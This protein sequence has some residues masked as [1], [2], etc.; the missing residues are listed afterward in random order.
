MA[1]QIANV[2]QDVPLN[3]GLFLHLR[4]LVPLNCNISVHML[5]YMHG[6][7]GLEVHKFS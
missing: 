2:P 7:A 6:W 3:R 4:T 1:F 5:V